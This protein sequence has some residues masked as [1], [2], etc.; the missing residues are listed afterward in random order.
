MHRIVDASIFYLSAREAGGQYNDPGLVALISMTS[1]WAAA[2]QITAMAV[3]FFFPKFSA[4]NHEA[5]KAGDMPL[6]SL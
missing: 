4:Y 1:R 5:F 2:I 3:T 6:F